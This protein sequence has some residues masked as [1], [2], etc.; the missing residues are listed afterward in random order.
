MKQLHTILG[1]GGAIAK[2]LTEE[3]LAK[4]EKVRLVSRN[5]QSTAGVEV[6]KADLTN[7]EQTIQAVQGSAVVYQC[8]GLDY[9]T[10]I[11]A[12]LWPVIMQ[13]T[14]EACKRTNSKLIFFDNVYMYGHVKGTQTEETPFHPISKKG[15]IRERI[16]TTLLNE[17]RAGNV[18]A[19]IARSADFY[20]L[21]AERTS[22][23][24]IMVLD[25]LY[26]GK[27]A[28]WLANTDAL[29]AYTFTQDAA[30]AL[31]ILQGDETAF[32]QTWHLPTSTALTG[33]EMIELVAKELGAEPNYSVL[34]KEMIQEYGSIDAFAKEI[35]EMLYQYE[36]HYLFDSFKFEKA[37]AFKP[38]S[39]QKG[40]QLTVKSSISTS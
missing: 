32:G 36:F 5:P 26:Q 20:G 27:P 35:Y 24:N 31:V 10:E 29:H 40:I 19:L 14:I 3:L 34:T 39:Y 11:W 30:K 22:I 12:S 6:V 8:V 18:Q 21:H 1:A 23:F 15:I 2:L 37:Y 4:N 9:N 38:T 33:K 28:Q 7:L 16:T 17:M 13:N 25:N